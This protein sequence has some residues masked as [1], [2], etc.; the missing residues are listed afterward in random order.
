MLRRMLE[1]PLGESEFGRLLEPATLE[2]SL[3]AAV[4]R[5]PDYQAANPAD[6]EDVRAVAQQTAHA[7]LPRLPEN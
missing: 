6:V 1:E 4:S 3:A 2:A 5:R 7:R